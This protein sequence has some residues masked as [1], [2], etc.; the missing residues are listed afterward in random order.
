MEHDFSG[1]TGIVWSCPLP[2]FDPYPSEISFWRM[3]QKR[4]R[5]VTKL[6]VRC[7]ES[8]Q[9][10]PSTNSSMPSMPSHKILVKTISQSYG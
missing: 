9:F 6:H 8:D 4:C 2:N 5:A 7:S 1:K 3:W 10:E